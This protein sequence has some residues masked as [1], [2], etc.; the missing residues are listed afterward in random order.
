MAAIKDLFLAVFFVSV[1]TLIGPPPSLYL[2]PVLL[3]S[4]ALACAGKALAGMALGGLLGPPNGYGRNP[5][6]FFARW[7]MP[8]GSSRWP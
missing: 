4:L 2:M 8:R 6:Y 5:T 7:L 1:G 3:L